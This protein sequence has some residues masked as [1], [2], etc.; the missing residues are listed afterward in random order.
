MNNLIA[1]FP[2]ILNFAQE[3][4]LPLLKKRA[5]LREYLQSQILEIIYRQ[6]V[7]AD[8]F[9]VGGTSLR[10]LRGLDR[11]SEDLD[12]DAPKLSKEDIKK[13]I[14]FTSQKLKENNLNL[15]LYQN[16][17]AKKDYYELRFPNL[18]FDLKLSANQSE[19]LTIKLDFEFF[20]HEQEREVILFNRYGFLSRIV[21]KTLDQILVEKMAAY[22]GR[23]QTQARDLYDLV[24]LMSN[25]AKFD[26]KFAK[27]NKLS[28]NLITKTKE[29]FKAEKKSLKA[30]K[31]KLRPFLLREENLEK[32]DFLEELLAKLS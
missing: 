2:Q 12:F 1:N 32:I 22:L 25:G 8:L 18:L 9:F 5:I 17:G 24:W 27:A 10:L 16:D 13:I 14:N 4:G 15:I 31:D 29:K 21:T 26:E 3:Y 23:A 28:K 7:S 30:A 6:K 11:F 19:N 20:W